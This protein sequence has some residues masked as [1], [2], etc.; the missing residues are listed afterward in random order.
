MANRPYIKNSIIEIERIFES[1]KN[2]INL[3]KQ[4]YNELQY[5]KTNRA[6]DLQKE[7]EKINFTEKIDDEIINNKIENEGLYHY[8]KIN[9]KNKLSEEKIQTPYFTSQENPTILKESKRK[10]TRQISKE[11]HH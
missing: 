2:D 7:I 1:S 6:K 3:V 11:C 5:R 4:I 10:K 8:P 9:N